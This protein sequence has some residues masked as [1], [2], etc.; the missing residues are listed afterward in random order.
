[1]VA[2]GGSAK[3]WGGR[4][5]FSRVP[6]LLPLAGEGARRADEGCFCSYSSKS[7]KAKAPLTPTL[8][9]KRERGLFT[10]HVRH[11][12]HLH[13]QQRMRQLVHRHRG[14]RRPALVEI[15]APDLVEAAEVV[16]VHQEAADLDQVLQP[17]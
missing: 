12:L 16:H 9:R 6:S 1:M 3:G 5:P 2:G 17:G 14:P 7:K 11:R 10:R 13:Q 15:L 4:S 8:S